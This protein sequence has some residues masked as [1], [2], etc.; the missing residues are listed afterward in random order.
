MKKQEIAIFIFLLMGFLGFSQDYTM[1]QTA[2]RKQQK[3]F[4]QAKGYSKAGQFEKA[5]DKL[6]KLLSKDTLFIDAHIL[7]AQAKY[8]LK[9]LEAAKS[10]Y[11]KALAIDANYYPVLV[12]QLGVTEWR[13]EEFELA[14]DHFEQ[15]LASQPRSKNLKSRAEKYLKNA[16][17]A[18]KAVKKPL[19]FEP[20]ALPLETIN[21]KEFEYLPSLSAD[22]KTLV[23][24]RRVEGQEDFY[25]SK[26]KNGEWQTAQPAVGINTPKNEGS[27]T[28]SADG[29]TL[30]F[31]ASGREDGFGRYDLYISKF[32]EGKFSTPTNMGRN[33]N[34]KARDRQPTLSSDGKIL[35]FES[36]RSG[37]L[38]GSDI[39]IS[40]RQTDDTWSKAQNLGAPINTKED[41]ESPFLHPDGKTLFFMSKGH[42]GM[43]GFDLYKSEKQADGSWGEPQNLGYPINTRAD[44]GALVVS[45]DG[46]TA[47]FTSSQNNENATDIF[48]FE[49][50]AS[51]RPSAITYVKAI[52]RDATNQKLLSNAKATFVNLS[53]GQAHTEAITD[54]DGEFLV[55]LPLENDFSLN[56]ST[57]GYLFYSEYFALEAMSSLAKPYELEVFLSPI[58]ITTNSKI[59]N[60]PI[61]LKNIFFETNSAQLL[62][63]SITE[64]R[65]LLALLQDQP[66]LC[67][68]INGHTDNIGSSEENLQLSEARAKAVYNFLLSEKINPK[69]LQYK[70]FGES[71]PIN[72][73]ETE[74]GRRSNRRTEFVV[75]NDNQSKEE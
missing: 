52:V 45:L 40:Y 5:I 30:V 32:R 37:G 35:L 13:L 10:S 36:S 19:P 59:I 22:Q 33:I 41:D 73:N 20:K 42:A 68:Q 47:Y 25:I 67:I 65:R 64:L 54:S 27:Q 11:E 2:T 70:G 23:F 44:E 26:M 48:S 6:D 63:N 46:K 7:K 60:Q 34:S 1:L 49:V 71:K 28:I 57:D 53:T 50:P 51:I 75:I 31:G 29:K 18:A 12:Y 43:G 24:T 58:P 14:A 74:A 69:R 39:W 4:E 3:Q 9:Q 38:G 72:S 8:E 56:I 61:V 66:Q 62:P 17:F 21:T 15:F 16:Q 55:I